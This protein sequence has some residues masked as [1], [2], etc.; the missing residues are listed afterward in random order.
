MDQALSDRERFLLARG[1]LAVVAL[2]AVANAL[3]PAQDTNNRLANQLKAIQAKQPMGQQTLLSVSSEVVSSVDSTLTE[4]VQMLQST[5]AE[6][7]A[8]SQSAELPTTEEFAVQNIIDVIK[9]SSPAYADKTD[10]EIKR[11][12]GLW[13]S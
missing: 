6:L 13:Q 4:A 11:L 9:Q 7:D 2:K 8:F 12:A 3:Q 5:L 10:D 1:D